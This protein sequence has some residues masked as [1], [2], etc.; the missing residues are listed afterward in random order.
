V[1]PNLGQNFYY[2][3]SATPAGNGI[4]LY[5]TGYTMPNGD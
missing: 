4:S 2:L 1:M 5:L 3:W